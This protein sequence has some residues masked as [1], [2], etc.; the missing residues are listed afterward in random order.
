[1]YISNASVEN[2]KYELEQELKYIPQKLHKY[3]MLFKKSGY[4]RDF[5][6]DEIL[7][8]F[9][10]IG[11]KYNDVPE[12][13]SAIPVIQ[14]FLKKD[15]EKAHENYRYFSNNE[16]IRA[17]TIMEV[18]LREQ[19]PDTEKR[20]NL[21]YLLEKG[22]TANHKLLYDVAEFTARLSTVADKRGISGWDLLSS[23]LILQKRMYE[24]M[25]IFDVLLKRC[26][27]MQTLW[28][29]KGYCLLKLGNLKK[30][31]YYLR[32]ATEMNSRCFFSW[33]RLA[34]LKW[35]QQKLDEALE[36][37]TKSTR[38][39]PGHPGPSGIVMVLQRRKEEQKQGAKGMV[40]NA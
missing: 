24:A 14:K 10:T 33:W 27:D 37:A 1:M 7:A 16:K 34:E 30:A 6:K 38:L 21:Y 39:N 15:T 9:D 28:A 20:G 12:I 5:F 19:Y 2:Y 31:E 17:K 22:E 26:P 13:S 11:K 8:E 25:E 4:Y 32:K 35:E 36:C 29:N 3:F 18:C 40:V 23:T